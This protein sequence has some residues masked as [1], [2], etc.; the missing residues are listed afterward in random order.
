MKNWQIFGIFTFLII[1]FLLIS[2]CTQDNYQYCRDK[3][4]GTVYNPSSKLCEKI[5]SE[6][7]TPPFATQSV[8]DE[9]IYTALLNMDLSKFIVDIPLNDPT[10]A[11]SCNLQGWS[12][13]NDD[14]SKDPNKKIVRIRYDCG[15]AWDSNNFMVRSA[16]VDT[17]IIYNLFKNPN[18]NKLILESSVNFTD[19]YGNEYQDIGLNV[20]FNRETA[21]KINYD[22][23]IPSLMSD[24]NKLLNIA[25]SYKINPG[26]VKNL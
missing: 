21:Q 25:E 18:V 11:F 26:I 7:P 24:Y 14:S 22:N 8:T 4:P 16:T 23:F 17:E 15:M 3:Y 9:N 12:V 5:I 1:G 10:N 6:T 13:I 19:K 20:T 2:G